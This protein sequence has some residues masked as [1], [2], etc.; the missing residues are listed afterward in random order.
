MWKT[1]FTESFPM[2]QTERKWESLRHLEHQHWGIL[3]P[4]V[5]D[6]WHFKPQNIL[7][8]EMRLLSIANFFAI[9]LQCNSI[10]RIT[11]QHNSKKKKLIFYCDGDREKERINDG[12]WGKYYFIVQIYYFNEQNKKIKVWDV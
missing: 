1:I 12:D 9:V 3:M 2:K 11:L 6:I 10:F 5:R 7:H 8:Q 4:N